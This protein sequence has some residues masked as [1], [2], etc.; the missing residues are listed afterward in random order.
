M[1]DWAVSLQVTY[2]VEGMCWLSGL[3]HCTYPI[4][5]KNLFAVFGVTAGLG[6]YRS[7]MWGVEGCLAVAT[8][9]D[10]VASLGHCSSPVLASTGYSRSQQVTAGG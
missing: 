1:V 2:L 4:L 6:C 8:A 7:H 9:A 3:G 10:P 5:D